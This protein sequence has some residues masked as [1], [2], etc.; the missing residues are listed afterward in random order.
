M[1]YVLTYL[2][3][4]LAFFL[5]FASPLFANN[6]TCCCLWNSVSRSWSSRGEIL[7]KRLWLPSLVRMV[8]LKSS[9]SEGVWESISRWIARRRSP[10]S[11]W[12]LLNDWTLHSHACKSPSSEQPLQMH[13]CT[14]FFLVPV[15][16]TRKWQTW[17]DTIRWTI[18]TCAQKRTSSQHSL[19]HDNTTN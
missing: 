12:R 15:K 2:L 9:C 14:Q 10:T 11:V 5:H 7:T 17:Y 4:F 16:R 13:T 1:T 6:A 19:T 8:A 3:A 18:L